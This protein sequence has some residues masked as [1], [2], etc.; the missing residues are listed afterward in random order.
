MVGQGLINIKVSRSHKTTHHSR[1]DFSVRVTDQSLGTQPGKTHHSQETDI[2]ARAIELAIPGFEPPQILAL[3]RAAP[4]I[5]HFRT[6]GKETKVT[7]FSYVSR[8]RGLYRKFEN[9]N[10]KVTNI[11]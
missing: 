11:T 5:G 7:K 3:D 8:A 6:I 4:G 2:H 10:K 1:Y 9:F